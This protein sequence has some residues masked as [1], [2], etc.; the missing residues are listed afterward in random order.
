MLKKM[1]GE[2]RAWEHKVRQIG[3][4]FLLFNNFM[5]AYNAFSSIPYPIAP[6]PS[7]TSPPLFLPNFMHSC[8]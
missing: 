3:L 2:E 8:L 5:H 7:L 6:N 4:I 1:F